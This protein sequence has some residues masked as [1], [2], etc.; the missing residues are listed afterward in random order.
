MPV[1][2]CIVYPGYHFGLAGYGSLNRG[3]PDLFG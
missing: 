2:H 3:H 1:V